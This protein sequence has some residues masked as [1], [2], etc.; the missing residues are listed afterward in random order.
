MILPAKLR[1]HPGVSSAC[2]MTHSAGRQGGG[3][4]RPQRTDRNHRWRSKIRRPDSGD[5]QR[6]VWRDTRKTIGTTGIRVA[7]RMELNDRC[8]PRQPDKWITIKGSSRPKPP[9]SLIRILSYSFSR[10]VVQR[11][12]NRLQQPGVATLPRSRSTFL[13]N[14]TCTIELLFFLNIPPLVSG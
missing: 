14:L 8:Q 13:R 1:P 9:L 12:S 2:R 11:G 5:E 4:G 10:S 7:N 3:E 6:R